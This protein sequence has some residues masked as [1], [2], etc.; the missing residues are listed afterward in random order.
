MSVPHLR[1]ILLNIGLGCTIIFVAG[2]FLD[3]AS[4]ARRVVERVAATARARA[5]DGPPSD[6]ETGGLSSVAVV[7]P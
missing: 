4:R 3:A 5:G 7:A 1:P 6:G 2:V